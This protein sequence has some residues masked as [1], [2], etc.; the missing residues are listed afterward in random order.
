MRLLVAEDDKALCLFLKRGLEMDGTDSIWSRMALQ[1][2]K[3]FG[4]KSPI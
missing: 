4:K 2:S 1:R 3:R